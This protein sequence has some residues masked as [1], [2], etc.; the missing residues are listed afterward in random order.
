[1][2]EAAIE[3]AAHPCSL[4]QERIDLGSAASV[5]DIEESLMCVRER[6]DLLLVAGG[7]VG[8]CETEEEVRPF[9]TRILGPELERAAVEAHGGDVRPEASRVVVF[10]RRREHHA[11]NLRPLCRALDALSQEFP[12]HEFLVVYSLQSF[13]CDPFLAMLPKERANLRGIAPLPYPAFVRELAR[14]RLV[15]TDSTGV[16]REAALLGRPLTVIGFYSLA[17]TLPEQVTAGYMTTAMEPESIRSAV[18]RQLAEPAPPE[19]PSAIEARPAGQLALEAIVEW[20]KEN[21][22]AR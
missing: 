7:E 9:R 8:K 21:K 10:M 11:N 13:I 2:L 19:A 4:G 16:A 6:D 12:D 5:A 22:S 17:T 20:W 15:I 18:A 3:V 14:A 1:M